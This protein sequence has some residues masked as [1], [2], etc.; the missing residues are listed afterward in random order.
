MSMCRYKWTCRPHPSLQASAWW[1]KRARKTG[2]I[3]LCSKDD[4]IVPNHLNRHDRKQLPLLSLRR[5]LGNVVQLAYSQWRSSLHSNVNAMVLVPIKTGMTENSWAT[6]FAR[7]SGPACECDGDVLTLLERRFN[8][9]SRGSRSGYAPRDSECIS[10]TNDIF[11][12]R[13]YRFDQSDALWHKTTLSENI[14]SD[15][16]TLIMNSNV[17]VVLWYANTYT[18]KCG[19]CKIV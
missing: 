10:M 2:N 9:C 19:C 1:T 3:S 14:Y 6:R 7:L 8:T 12:T 16:T 15:I 4:T 11:C 18:A 13:P 5:R 17:S